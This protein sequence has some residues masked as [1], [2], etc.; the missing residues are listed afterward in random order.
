MQIN[1]MRVLVTGGSGFIGTNLCQLFVNEGI[2]VCNVDLVTTK[3]DALSSSWVRGDILDLPSLLNIFKSYQPDAVV[4][5]A[6]E[7]DTAPHMTMEHYRVNTEGTKN[8]LTAIKANP[9]VKRFVLT[10]T[11][12]VNQNPDGPKH[13]EDYSPYTVYGES[14]MITEQSLRKSDLQ[15]TWTIIR[16]TNVWGPWHLRYPFEFWKVLAEGK[17]FH[18]GSKKVIRSYG[19]VGNVVN[20]VLTIL[21]K[22]QDSVDR[23]VYYVGDAPIDLYDWVNGFSLKQTG[24]PVTVVPRLFIYGLALVGDALQ[25]VKIKFPITTSRYKSMTTDNP[26]YMGKTFEELG[27]PKYTLTEGIEE[28]VKWM[29]TV[30]P[31]LVRKK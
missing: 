21:R 20:Q 3:V 6:A 18:P 10:S 31:H 16:P 17:Y 13:D 2:D 5:L 15:C 23:K 22:P 8:V 9:S 29:K 12:F 26:A 14:K 1:N 27:K 19:Y 25:Q 11:Q 24:K 7:T 30:H 4:H 28:T